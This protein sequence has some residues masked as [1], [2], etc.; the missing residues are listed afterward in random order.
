MTFL[1]N[2][3]YFT[4][5]G[6]IHISYEDVYGGELVYQYNIYEEENNLILELINEHFTDRYESLASY[7][8][9]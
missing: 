6:I 9:E 7:T 2:G 4:E 5:D 1:Y 3:T 8:F